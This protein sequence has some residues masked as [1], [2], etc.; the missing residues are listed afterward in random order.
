MAGRC[1]SD[2]FK[3]APS[4]LTIPDYYEFVDERDVITWAFLRTRTYTSHSHFLSAVAQLQLNARV[5]NIGCEVAN[6]DYTPGSGKPETEFKGPGRFPCRPVSILVDVFVERVHSFLAAPDIASQVRL[7]WLRWHP[8]QAPPARL[9]Q[10]PRTAWRCNDFSD[11]LTACM[12]GHREHRLSLLSGRRKCDRFVAGTQLP[13]QVRAAEYKVL[14]GHLFM[15]EDEQANELLWCECD[16][17]KK[18]R[19]VDQQT[20]EQV[21]LRDEY[22]CATDMRRPIRGCDVA[23][24]PN[25]NVPHDDET[26]MQSALGLVDR[27]VNM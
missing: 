2:P 14:A 9:G 5:Y 4:R 12:H 17:C 26:L 18:W 19:L 27:H 20:H 15:L 25:S 8:F 3:K 16:I 7:P 21:Q 11:I 1:C 6:K 23:L 22:L 13:V 24:L 10:N